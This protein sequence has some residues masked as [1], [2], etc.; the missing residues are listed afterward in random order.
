EGV[1][2]TS[3]F[4]EWGFRID[5]AGLNWGPLRARLAYESIHSNLPEE[6]PNHTVI[7][8]KIPNGSTKSKGLA[9]REI[10]RFRGHP[11]LI[12]A[13]VGKGSIVLAATSYFLSNEAMTRE[14][15]PELLVWLIGGKTSVIF[16]EYHHG[17]ASNPGVATLARKYDLQWL[18]FAL[19]LIAL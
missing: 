6:L 11:V 7:Y 2:I 3:L 13:P 14:R 18:F 12:E 9:W 15:L 1:R 16:D 10:Y 8:F 19:I 17:V 4:Q 5:A